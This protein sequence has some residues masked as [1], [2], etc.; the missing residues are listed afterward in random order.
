LTARRNTGWL[1]ERKAV[2]VV[3]WNALIKVRCITVEQGV[4]AASR[5]I[6]I[7]MKAA[8]QLGLLI[9]V[10]SS[11]D[12]EGIGSS[13]PVSISGKQE[14]TGITAMTIKAFGRAYELGKEHLDQLK[15]MRVNGMQ[16][17]YEGGY[18]E[19]GGRTLYIQLS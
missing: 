4:A 1:S 3:T 13:G 5:E 16:L 9:I 2:Q 18:K 8:I 15:S 14:A 7:A 19:L 17:S 12:S 11:C 6:V 10:I